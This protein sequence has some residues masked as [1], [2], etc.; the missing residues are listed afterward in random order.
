MI[1]QELIEEIGKYIDMY[2]TP[3]DKEIKSCKNKEFVFK[4]IIR[5]WRECTKRALTWTGGFLILLF[6]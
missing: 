4:R 5:F 6:P 1:N 3:E 2:Y